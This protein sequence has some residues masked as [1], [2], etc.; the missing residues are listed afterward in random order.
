MTF[1]SITN[2]G[3]FFSNHY[4]DA[5]IGGDLGDMRSAWDEAEGRSEPS[6]R[7]ALRGAGSV[8]FAARAI[9]SEA[10]GDRAP[11]AIRSLNDGVLNSL[12]FT[13]QRLG[14]THRL[15]QPRRNSGSLG[16]SRL[17]GH[18]QRKLNK[19]RGLCFPT[20]A[21]R[22]HWYCRDGSAHSGLEGGTLGRHCRHAA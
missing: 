22:Q 3:E 15:Y 16:R 14:R 6:A 19:H 9:A 13:S 11:D 18:D 21:G 10:T 5:V 1:P 12:G 17:P 8:F 20:R 2:R 7:S 4:L